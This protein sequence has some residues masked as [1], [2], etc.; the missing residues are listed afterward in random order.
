M[1]DYPP[2]QGSY[3]VTRWIFG[4]MDDGIR[5]KIREHQ[6]H[7]WIKYKNSPCGLNYKQLKSL[8]EFTTLVVVGF[9]GSQCR[10]ACS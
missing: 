5:F 1:T 4:L 8:L 3:G 10:K 2:T 9:V 6:Y 7:S